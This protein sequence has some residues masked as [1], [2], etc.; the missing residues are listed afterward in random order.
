M[1]GFLAWFNAPSEIDEVLKAGL[2]HFWFITIH[3]FDDGN[4]RIARAIADMALAR[5]EG[6]PLRFYSMSSQI[7]R[8]RGEY[9]RIL[10]RTQKGTTDVS[11]WMNWFVACLGPGD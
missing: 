3:P 8:E 6:S 7:Q 4:G 11:E 1:Q 10:E 9:Y 5:S 2:S